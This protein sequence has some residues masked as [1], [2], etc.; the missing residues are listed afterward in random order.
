MVRADHE[1]ALTLGK[2][3]LSLAESTQDEDLL[4]Q[5]HNALGLAFFFEGDFADSREH[6]ERCLALYDLEKHRSLAFSYASTI[7]AARPETRLSNQQCSRAINFRRAGS[8]LGEALG[9]TAA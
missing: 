4:L 5:A 6:L 7:D 2:H 8:V 9:T 1:K 3:L